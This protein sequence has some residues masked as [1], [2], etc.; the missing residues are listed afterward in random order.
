VVTSDPTEARYILTPDFMSDLYD[1][2]QSKK[3]NIRIVFKDNRMYVL[4][5]DRDVKFGY[6]LVTLTAEEFKKYLLSIARPLL[7]VLHLV[8]DVEKRF[9]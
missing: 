8:E 2:W 3:T 6:T 4:Y 5:P 7:H 9:R 1:W